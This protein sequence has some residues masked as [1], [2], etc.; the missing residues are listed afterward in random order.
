MTEQAAQPA[1]EWRLECR[2]LSVRRAGRPVLTD[3]SFTLRAGECACLVGPNGSGKTTLL[4]SLLGLLTPTGGSVR[5]N[6]AEVCRLSPR[7]RARFA[8][9]VP[10]VLQHRP[11]LSVAD[12]VAGGRFA[13]VGPWRG[14]TSHDQA[15]VERA[16]AAC[17]LQALRERSFSALSGGEQQKTLLAAAIAQDPQVLLLDEPNT[18]LDPAFQLE[19]VRILRDWHSG[20]RALL[21]VSHDLQLPAV[22]AGRLLAMR[23]GRIVADGPAAEVL[24]PERLAAVYDAPF[25][26]LTSAGGRQLVL[27]EWW[28]GR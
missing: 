9:Y 5:L 27:P 16:I 28:R 26:A 12:V 20:G 23:G 17:G 13:H 4:L 14:L 22:L 19:L 21:I 18:A 11:A 7:R 1:D 10:Q 3:V 15:A 8:A 24:Q 6:D 25:A 2:G